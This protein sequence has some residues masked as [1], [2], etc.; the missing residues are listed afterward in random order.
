MISADQEQTV[1][2][3]DHWRNVFSRELME[4]A[5]EAERGNRPKRTVMVELQGEEADLSK[6]LT[7]CSRNI[8]TMLAARKVVHGSRGPLQYE[9]LP[10]KDGK[11]SAHRFSVEF[12]EEA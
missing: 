6:V 1:S 10:A 3:R 11:P 4:R 9:F 7:I 8:E 2:M 5:D 12:E